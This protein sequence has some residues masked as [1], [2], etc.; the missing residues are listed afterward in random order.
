MAI[1]VD[2]IMATR[3]ANKEQLLWFVRGECRLLSRFQIVYNHLYFEDLRYCTQG[4]GGR[5]GLVKES[6]CF[7]IIKGLFGLVAETIPI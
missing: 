7:K 1:W 3:V 5:W 2:E 4:D 6:V